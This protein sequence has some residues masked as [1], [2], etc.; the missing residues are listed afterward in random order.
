MRGVRELARGSDCDLCVCLYRMYGA[1]FMWMCAPFP[2]R[3]EFSLRVRGV[4]VGP[5]GGRVAVGGPGGGSVA[6]IFASY[7]LPDRWGIRLYCTV[8]LGTS[9][10]T[11]CTPPYDIIPSSR[12]SSSAPC[13]LVARSGTQVVCQCFQPC[14]SSGRLCSPGWPCAPLPPPPSP[15]P[16]WWPHQRSGLTILGLGYL[17]VD[18]SSSTRGG[19]CDQCQTLSTQREI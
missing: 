16:A 6:V 12:R 5:S 9:Y 11:A 18:V 8:G 17:L 7:S 19:T 15:R 13:C 2:S 10:C 3:C 4:A 1:G 14:A